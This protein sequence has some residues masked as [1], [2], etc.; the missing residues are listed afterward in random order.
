M[1]LKRERER[2]ANKKKGGSLLEIKKTGINLDNIRR[3]KQGK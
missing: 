2:E 3:G 1:S